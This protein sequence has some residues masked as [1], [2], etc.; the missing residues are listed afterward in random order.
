MFTEGR[1]YTPTEGRIYA[2]AT[3]KIETFHHFS[4]F[5]F[6]LWVFSASAVIVNGQVD[7]FSIE[8]SYEVIIFKF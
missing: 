7:V 8:K 4:S 1:I 2:P 3:G 5:N 6:I